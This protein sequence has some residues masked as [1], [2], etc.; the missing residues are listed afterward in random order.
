MGTIPGAP[1]AREGVASVAKDTKRGL[2]SLAFAPHPGQNKYE[3]AIIAA[4][5]ARHLNELS[6]L[7]GEPLAGKVTAVALER[8]L[9]EEVPFTYEEPAPTPA[10]A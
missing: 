8:V 3:L 9:R 4:R 5:E 1:S 6:R 7:T 2:R 10:E